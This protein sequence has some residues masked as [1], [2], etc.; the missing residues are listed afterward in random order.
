MSKVEQI[1]Q[2]LA[3]HIEKLDFV[4]DDVLFLMPDS[5]FYT[6]EIKKGELL[7]MR[8]KLDD[9]RKKKNFPAFRFDKNV[10]YQHKILLKE[11]NIALKNLVVKK[12][13]EL[14]EE[15][16]LESDGLKVACMISL[17]KEY[18]L[19]GRLRTYR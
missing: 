15:L 5:Y 19:L 10:E 12:K 16:Y 13:S 18:N 1:E 14:R 6:P 3:Q 7:H 9:L 4:I 2:Y 8:Q 17:I 11:Y